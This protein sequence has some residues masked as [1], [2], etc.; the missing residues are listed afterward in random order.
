[1]GES[2]SEYSNRKG[3]E[4]PHASLQSPD[5]ANNAHKFFILPLSTSQLQDVNRFLKTGQELYSSEHLGKILRL[6]T[7]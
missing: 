7:T 2:G 6:N 1:M 3:E 5:H 4:L